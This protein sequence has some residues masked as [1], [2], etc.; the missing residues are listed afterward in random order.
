LVAY[1]LLLLQNDYFFMINRLRVLLMP[2]LS[3][4]MTRGTITRWHV[5]PRKY[6]KSYDLVVEISVNDLTAPAS[7]SSVPTF[8]AMEIE[9]MED[10]YLCRILADA[11]DDPLPVGAPLALLSEE[12][13]DSGVAVEDIITAIESDKYGERKRWDSIIKPALWQAYLKTNDGNSCGCS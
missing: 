9:I 4:T 3:P 12:E 8:T 11:G 1:L 2:P 7:T 10:M 6:L 13:S 5:A